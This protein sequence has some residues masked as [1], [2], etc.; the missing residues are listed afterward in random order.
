MSL[1]Q[2]VSTGEVREIDD[3]LIA[4]WIDASNPK[5][6]SWQA[7]TP[8]PPQEPT[9]PTPS[10]VWATKLAGRITDPLTGIQIEASEEV[11]NI[12]TGQ[13]AMTM[14]ALS[15]GAIQPTTTQQLWDADGT[16]HTMQTSELIG[17]M[18]RH[19]S[20]WQTMFAEFAP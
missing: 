14:A 1:R 13:L 20:Q 18:L 10:E 6:E 3:A 17:L 15:V 5:A 8:P 7:Y 4:A 11:R 9:P 16:V 19:G 2:N 12:L